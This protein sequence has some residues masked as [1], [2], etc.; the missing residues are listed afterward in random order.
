M[1]YSP[2]NLDPPAF[3]RFL[4]L[5]L[6]LLALGLTVPAGRAAPGDEPQGGVPPEEVMQRLREG[7]RRFVRDTLQA[8]D[9]THARKEVIEQQRPFV[10]VL[11]CSDS[12]VPTELVFDQS[13]GALFIVRVAGNVVDPVALGSI[14][15]GTLVL[16]VRCLL[17]LGHQSCGAVEAAV[18]RKEVPPNIASILQ[19]IEPAAAE[20]RGKGLGKTETLNAAIKENVRVQMRATL[21]ESDVLRKAVASGQLEVDGGV[22]DLHTGQVEFLPKLAGL[23]GGAEGGKASR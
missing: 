9:L 4:P 22:Y 23:G 13:I 1:H 7:N 14:E 21:A 8:R 19:R 18:D 10:T 6:C 12:R 2:P 16:G 20:V 3:W 5:A 17:V 11:S 15:Y